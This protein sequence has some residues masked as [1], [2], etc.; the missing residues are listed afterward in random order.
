MNGELSEKQ[1]LELELGITV[2]DSYENVKNF[3]DL[4]QQVI[5]MNQRLE[6]LLERFLIMEEYLTDN[7]I[8]HIE[9]Y[10]GRIIDSIKKGLVIKKHDIK[11]GKK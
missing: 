10:E 9:E 8:I 5:R 6:I 7:E 4:K 2:R 3:K 1:N 11:E